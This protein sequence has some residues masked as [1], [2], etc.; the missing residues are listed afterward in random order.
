[1]AMPKAEHDFEE[2]CPTLARLASRM[3]GSL[4][5]DAVLV[6]DGDGKA[7]AALGPIHGADRIAR[8]F[9]G[10]L[11]KSPSEMEVRRVRVNGRPGVMTLDV[12]DGHVATC[13]I[14]RNPDKM[15]RVESGN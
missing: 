6:S 2:H 8:F 5:D 12:A 3:L 4:A 13:F 7:T 10:I 1:M 15:E 9:L 14:V 11:K